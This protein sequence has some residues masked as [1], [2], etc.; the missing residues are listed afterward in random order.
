MSHSE[1]LKLASSQKPGRDSLMAKILTSE[2]VQRLFGQRQTMIEAQLSVTSGAM[3]L[4][5]R[6]GRVE[7]QMQSR[8]HA[9]ERRIVE[10]E[11]ELAESEEL[12][13]ELIRAKIRT[14]RLEL[15]AAQAQAG[16]GE[17]QPRPRINLN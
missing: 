5:R 7:R 6:L 13:R 8:F 16:E 2:I 9:Y 1:L 15:Q 17:D 10:L 11:K 12:S 4:E 14:A 3:A